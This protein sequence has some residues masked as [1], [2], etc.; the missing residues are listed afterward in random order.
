MIFFDI[1]DFD[2]ISQQNR[3]CNAHNVA[4]KGWS[5]GS[6]WYCL[7]SMWQW[8]SLI[9]SRT[10]RL[11][12]LG[13]KRTRPSLWYREKRDLSLNTQ[14]IQYMRSHISCLR[15]HSLQ[16]HLSSNVKL[17]HLAGCCDR[18]P[19]TQS[20]LMIF[21]AFILLSTQRII[22]VLRRGS[23]IKLLALPYGVSGGLP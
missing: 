17:G 5:N 15:T 12:C 23:E 4:P 16:R 6:N 8:L 19:A 13:C 21:P 14:C 10:T 11:P 1:P 9:Q 2:K 3:K 7:V 22:S 20:L 18:Y